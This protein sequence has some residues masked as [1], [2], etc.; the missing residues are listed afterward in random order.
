MDTV[1]SAEDL[2]MS[3]PVFSVD[4]NSR[5]AFFVTNRQ[6]VS[7][8]S[9]SPW[10]ERLENELNDSA[11]TGAAFRIGV[12]SEGFQTLREQILRIP[13]GTGSEDLQS[14]P[15]SGCVVLRDSDLGYFL[16]TVAGEQPHAVILDMPDSQLSQDIFGYDEEDYE[17]DAKVLAIG[18]PRAA[19]QPPATLWTQSALSDFLDTRV[20]ARHKKTLKEEIRLSATTLDLMT[21]AHRVLSHETHRLGIAAADLFRRCEWLQAE[22]RDQ[23]RLAN[24][25]GRRVERIA[26]ED[27][28]DYDEKDPDRPRGNA[29]LEQRLEDAQK[30][31]KEL[32]ERHDNLRKK[33]SKCGA[34]EL[35]D[36][37]QIWI[38]E[39]QRLEKSLSNSSAKEQ[40]SRNG[41][42]QGHTE[43]WRR[44]E[45]VCLL[46]N[47][48]ISV[49]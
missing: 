19:Y 44:Y 17:P 45:E 18:P 16:L 43:P 33:L 30:R 22:F 41:K 8:F 39:V 25:L 4:V 29:A 6:S 2:E 48:P 7:Y 37:E 40:E 26:D 14:R 31:Q 11:S 47:P 42:R 34:R 5:Y 24:D 21:E 15:L 23:I 3:W 20:H 9:L 32:V 38:W 27:A 1:R 28:D 10:V 35:S 36:K 13:S 12:F 49:C 46:R